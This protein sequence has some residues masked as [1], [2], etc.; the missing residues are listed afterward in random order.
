MGNATYFGQFQ[1]IPNFS[2]V[3]QLQFHNVTAIKIS[4]DNNSSMKYGSIYWYYYYYYHHHHHHH[5]HHHYR[6]RHQLNEAEHVACI[7]KTRGIHMIMIMIIYLSAAIGL[8]LGGIYTQTIHRTTQIQTIN[9]T[10]QIQTIIE[11]HK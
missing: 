9:R 7:Q 11:Q 2:D 3:V 4:G 8:T 6:H 10:T 5:S 1:H